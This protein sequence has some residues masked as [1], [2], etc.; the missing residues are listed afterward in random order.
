MVRLAKI[1]F[2]AGGIR[3][4]PKGK[5]TARSMIEGLH[6]P[7]RLSIVLP[8]QFD[9]E[10]EIVVELSGFTEQEEKSL[11]PHTQFVMIEGRKWSVSGEIIHENSTT[12]P[13][14]FGRLQTC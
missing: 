1:K 11:L 5:Y 12:S 2:R 6:Y 10:E 13:S 14:I 3:R 8:Q 7:S 4:L 9:F